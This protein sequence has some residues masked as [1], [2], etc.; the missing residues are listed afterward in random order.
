[1]LRRYVSQANI[2]PKS[3]GC[4]SP[5]LDTQPFHQCSRSPLWGNSPCNQTY[6]RPS[7]RY[8]PRGYRSGSLLLGGGTWLHDGWTLLILGHLVSSIGVAVLA[9]VWWADGETIDGQTGAFSR[10]VPTLFVIAGAVLTLIGLVSS[11]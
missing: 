9:V 7:G 11:R 4:L 2:G 8:R 10:A 6:G 3:V 1:M 5:L